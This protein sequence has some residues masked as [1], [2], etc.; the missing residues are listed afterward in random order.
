MLGRNG[1]AFSWRM[2]ASAA[3]MSAW[4]AASSGRLDQGNGHQVVKAPA[5]IDQRDLHV[6]VLQRL[7]DRS[8]IQ[9]QHL[10]QIRALNSPLLPRSD[11]LLLEVGQQVPG[12]SNLDSRHQFAAQL[13][14]PLDQLVSTLT[15]IESTGVHAPMLVHLKVGIG[16][17]EQGVILRSLDAPVPG[18]QNLSRG[19]G[20]EDGIG[21]G[22]GPPHTGTAVKEI[23]GGRGH[24]AFVEIGT[25]AVVPNVVKTDV[26]RGDPE[27][28]CSRELGFG[29]PDSGLSRG[30]DQRPSVREPKCC[31]QVDGKAKV[32]RFQ[33]S[34]LQRQA[35]CQRRW[36][37]DTFIRGP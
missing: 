1:R 19:Q 5:G 29:D 13:R 28:L 6:V 35:G 27:E 16:R 3:W 31:G 9:P 25:A 32:G 24:D 11:G 21:R 12:S 17:L 2:Y 23:D 4:L 30:D 20:L 10:R 26:Q 22:D 14:D 8:G 7:N 37:P 18:I 15:R 34:P 36:N 33:R